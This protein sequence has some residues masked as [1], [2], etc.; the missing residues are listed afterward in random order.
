MAVDFAGR[1]SIVVYRHEHSFLQITGDGFETHSWE[2]QKCISESGCARK[3]GAAGNIPME[4]ENGAWQKIT[5][6]PGTTCG[7]WREADVP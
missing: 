2:E 5:G 4:A 7:Q 6:T 3:T 1:N